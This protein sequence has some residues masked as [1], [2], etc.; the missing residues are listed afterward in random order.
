MTG[1]LSLGKSQYLGDINHIHY[2]DG[3][4]ASA[5]TA[6]PSEISN[7][8]L[9]YHENPIISFILHGDSIERINHS[10]NPRSAGDIRFYPAGALHQVKIKRFPSRNLNFELERDFLAR[11]GL[12]EESIARALEKSLDA[13][14][15]F[16]RAYK[17]F[18]ANDE[19]S[20]ASIQILLLNLLCAGAITGGR[21]RPA[22]INTLYQLLN[23]RWNEQLSLQELSRII[24]VHPVT[25]SK[26]FTRY[27]AC[28]L[29]EYMR[30]LRIEKSIPLIKNSGLSLTDIASLCGFADQSHFTRNFKAFTGFL[31]KDFRKL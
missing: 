6:D 10:T 24:N 3:M 16:L 4:V 14:L 12:S 7:D 11:S 19:F 18:S 22:W 2:L 31:P 26:Y 28:T 8:A 27:F 25:I 17:E 29:G 15:L 5:L 9:H 30:K 1:I 21:R 13:R 20:D 23:D